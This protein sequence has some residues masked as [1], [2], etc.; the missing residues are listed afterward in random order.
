MYSRADPQLSQH[1]LLLPKKR[2]IVLCDEALLLY[3]NIGYVYPKFNRKEYFKTTNTYVSVKVLS[4]TYGIPKSTLYKAVKDGRLDYIKIGRSTR[5]SEDSI[6]R[7]YVQKDRGSSSDRG[8][9]ESIMTTTQQTSL[10]GKGTIQKKKNKAGTIYYQVIKFPMCYDDDGNIVYDRSPCFRTKEEAEQARQE[11]IYKRK[12]A[13][14]KTQNKS[15]LKTKNK[16]SA[17]DMLIEFTELYVFPNHRTD[18]G[19]TDVLGQ[20]KRYYKKTLSKITIE[21]CSPLHIQRILNDMN[22]KTSPVA[23]CQIIRKFFKWLKQQE[24]I[25]KNPTEYIVCPKHYP[26]RKQNRSPLTKEEK[27][28]L[29]NFLE[30]NHCLARRYKHVI[31]VLLCTGGRPGEVAGMERKNINWEY[32]TIRIVK[33]V[34]DRHESKRIRDMTKTPKGQRTVPL[35]DEA[36]EA[37][38]EYFKRVPDSPWIIPSIK[39]KSQP[40]MLDCLKNAIKRIGKNAGI[41]R[42]LFG[43]LFRHTFITDAVRAKIPASDLRFIT[44]H[45]DTKMINMVYANHQNEQIINVYRDILNK[46]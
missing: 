6:R 14:I 13:P 17:Y 33:T 35:S 11:M 20:F 39:D 18:K 43:Y 24:L 16:K 4:D 34:A 22:Q 27:T 41:K 44:G 21:E 25:Q 37:L 8:E 38:K 12:Y 45:S 7:Y 23:T 31:L 46:M 30:T 3:N 1:I 26:N 28:L 40:I 2:L 5:I 29:L 10:T 15:S 19:K 36:C 42:S 9:G 32:K